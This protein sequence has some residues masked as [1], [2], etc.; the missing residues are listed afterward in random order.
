MNEKSHYLNQLKDYLTEKEKTLCFSKIYLEE[1]IFKDLESGT[2]YAD[3]EAL[4]LSKFMIRTNLEN[5]INLIF[6]NAESFFEKYF[7]NLVNLNSLGQYRLIFTPKFVSTIDT[8]KIIK[9]K[10]EEVNKLFIEFKKQTNK[11]EK[12]FIDYLE[13]L[14]Q[15]SFITYD[16][17][18]ELQYYFIFYRGKFGLIN[19]YHMTVQPGFVD[20]VI[21]NHSIR[22]DALIWIPNNPN[23]KL[24]IECDGFQF[25]SGKDKFITDRKRDRLLQTMGFKVFRFSGTEFFKDPIETTG[26]LHTYLKNNA[27]R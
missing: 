13:W 20:V 25:H 15:K 5:N 26:E 12:D 7:L 18:M 8:I 27:K 9:E 6:A 14:N 2:S 19:A 24:I 1:F 16:E 4:E 22:P 21:N 23:F 3:K 11:K 17:K 10:E